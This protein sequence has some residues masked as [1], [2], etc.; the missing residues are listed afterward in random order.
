MLKGNL[1]ETDIMTK[2]TELQLEFWIVV[3]VFEKVTV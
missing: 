2:F 1:A 3:K